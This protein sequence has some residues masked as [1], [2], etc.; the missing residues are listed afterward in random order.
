MNMRPS[1]V[2]GHDNTHLACAKL[3]GERCF[4]CVHRVVLGPHI[5]NQVAGINLM[6]RAYE[7]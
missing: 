4:R 2:I 3:R 1:R 6:R 5:P 7:D